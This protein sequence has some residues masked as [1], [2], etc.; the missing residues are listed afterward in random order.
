MRIHKTSLLGNTDRYSEKTSKAN[1]SCLFA[2]ETGKYVNKLGSIANKPLFIEIK[3]TSRADD[4]SFVG[5]F[6]AFRWKIYI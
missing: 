1:K 6:K 3:L 4:G 2:K 5:D